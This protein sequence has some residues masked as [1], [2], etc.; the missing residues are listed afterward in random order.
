MLACTS[1]SGNVDDWMVERGVSWPSP[2]AMLQKHEDPR[3][4][5]PSAFSP[6]RRTD[7]CNGCWLRQIAVDND[8]NVPP[9]ARPHGGFCDYDFPCLF[10]TDSFSLSA[11][12]R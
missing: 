7:R 1:S 2:I 12:S 5:A 11:R 4:G 9:V 10:S 6:S 3:S 8:G